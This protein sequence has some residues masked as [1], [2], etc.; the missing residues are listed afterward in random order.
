[1]KP[2]GIVKVAGYSFLAL[3]ICMLAGAI[4]LYT[5]TNAF[6][7]DAVQAEGTVTEVVRSYWDGSTTYQ[8]VVRFRTQQGK[9]I[10]FTSSSSTSKRP[11]YSTGQT[12]EVLYRPNAP[13]IAE[14]NSFLLLW[15]GSILWGLLGSSFSIF[16]ATILI[17]SM[18]KGRK[19]R[20]EKYFKQQGTRIET[21]FKCI[22]IN[23]MRSA[24]HQ[25]PFQVVTQWKNPSTS[26]IHIFESDNL[27]YNPMGYI[28]S[29]H[30]TVFIEKDNPKKY[31]V[32]LSFISDDAD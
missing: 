2:L 24:N 11:G 8:P 6:L 16:G 26:E 25:H 3:S 31:L 27:W 30:I 13:Q 28:K 9:E 18:L 7:K 20:K 32:D 17:G 14:I 15:G 10:E 12:V 23:T 21:E 29:K 19:G 22:K 1:M 4:L 5:N